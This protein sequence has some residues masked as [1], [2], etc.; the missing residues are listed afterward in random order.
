[1]KNTKG[2]I[3]LAEDDL[4]L[5]FLTTDFLEENGYTIKLCKDG[6]SAL[7][8]FKHE[9]FDLCILDVMMP[10]KDGFELAKEIRELNPKA[11]IIFLTARSMKEDKL[12]GFKLG[13]DDFITKPFEEEELLARIEAII[14]RTK[15]EETQSTV[16]NFDIG[17]YNFDFNNQAIIKGNE[18][19]RITERE[20]K[21]LKELCLNKNQIS[22]REDLLVSVWGTNDYFL[23]RSLDV[24]ITKLRKYLKGDPTVSIENIH[25]VGFMLKDGKE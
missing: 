10:L 5:G 21:I 7:K 4:N 11:P 8:A 13:A 1:M 14:R 25:G 6:E 12:T 16:I 24:F 19:K 15:K 23:G 20:A 18:I 2:K 9:Q 3:L 17:Q 22:K